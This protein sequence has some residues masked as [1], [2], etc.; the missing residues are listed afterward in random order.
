MYYGRNLDWGY[1]F[2]KNPDQQAHKD[3]RY[4]SIPGEEEW[5]GFRR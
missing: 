1:V 2:G 3:E 4:L 5:Y